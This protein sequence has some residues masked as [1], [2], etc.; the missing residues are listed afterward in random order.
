MSSL[1]QVPD[2]VAMHDIL[3]REIQLLAIVT[4]RCM[5]LAL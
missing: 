1:H 3:V 4:G 2:K 5:I